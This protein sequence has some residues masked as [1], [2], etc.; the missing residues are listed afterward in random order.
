M[1]LKVS[2]SQ[3]CSDWLYFELRLWS[4]LIIFWHAWYLLQPSAKHI[5]LNITFINSNAVYT[6]T[7]GQNMSE[8]ARM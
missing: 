7:Q 5:T 6:V 4:L 3:K 1:S 8:A 2:I